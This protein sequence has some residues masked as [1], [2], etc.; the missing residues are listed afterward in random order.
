MGAI[1]FYVYYRY[2]EI[3]II[4]FGSLLYSSFI[5]ASLVFS[6]LGAYQLEIGETHYYRVRE[7]GEVHPGKAN[8]LE[9]IDVAV[10]SRRLAYRNPEQVPGDLIAVNSVCHL[11][12][13][14]FVVEVHGSGVNRDRVFVV[15]FY[16]VDGVVPVQVFI[17]G[18]VGAR[19]SKGIISTHNGRIPFHV[20]EVFVSLQNQRLSRIKLIAEIVLEV[21]CRYVVS[22]GFTC[23]RGYAV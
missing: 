18:E 21:I 13:N 5:Q 4:G 10:L 23:R 2:K 3:W 12:H 14:V 22:D 16:I 7:L 11:I 17:V 20:V 6:P 19:G 8:G 1:F 15:F 9:A